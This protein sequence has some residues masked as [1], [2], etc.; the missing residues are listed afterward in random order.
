METLFK[1]I[2]YGIRSLAKH[3]GFAAIA[4]ITLALGIGANTA[5]FS[6]VNAVLLRPLPY[7]QPERLLRVWETNLARGGELEMTS[8]SNLLD[9]RRQNRSFQDLAAWQRLSSLTLTSQTPALQL[10]SSFVSANYFSLLGVPAALGRTFAVEESTAGHTRVVVISDELWRRQFGSNPQMIG[11]KILIEKENFEIIGVMPRGFKSPAG[12]AELWVPMNFQPNDIDRGQTYLQ[13]IGRLKPDFTLAQA[14]ADMDGVATQLAAQFPNSNRG[15]GI[16]LVSLAEQTVGSVRRALLIVLGGV[17]LVLLIACANV[18][19]LFLVRAAQ[20]QHE[21]AIRAALGASSRR[22][23]RQLLS[24]ASIVALCGGMLGLFAAVWALELLKAF[25]AGQLPRLDEIGIDRPTLIFT[26]AASLITGLLSGLAPALYVCRPNLNDALKD[27][28]S[29]TQTGGWRRNRLQS[30][31]VVAQVAVA[32]VLLS[33]AGLL[34]RSFVQLVKVNPGFTADG[35]LVARIALGD[36]YRQNNKQVNYFRELT[37]RLRRLP[38]VNEAGAATVLPMN[39]FGIDFD[40][41]YHR[42]EQ[43]EPP[44]A[45]APKAKFRAVTPEYFQA[46]EM[47]LHKGRGFVE[48]DRHDSPRVL[49][50]NQMLAERVWRAENPVGKQLRFF[51]AD[52]QT[53]EVVGVVGNT[54]SYGLVE[55]YQPELFVP[56]AQIPYTVMNVVIRT[57]GDPSASAVE[58]RRV[59]LEL[60]PYRPPHSIVA[61]RDLIS[62]SIARERFAMTWLGVLAAI[63]LV[64]ASVGIYSVI[65][66]VTAQ[67]TREVG[68]R[69]ALGAQTSDVLRLVVLKGMK[70]TLI[71]VVIGFA[72]ALGLT[73]LIGS[74]LFGV[75]SSDLMT[76]ISAS[77]LLIV[78]ALLACYVPARRA[79]KVDP[80]VALRYE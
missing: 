79:T 53:Y 47:P 75:T 22:L 55:D 50:V 59:I 6:V 14:Q 56:D 21:I 52:W 51:W 32:L 5:I 38:G 11:T 3:P 70:L 35:L 60:D 19:N 74:L 41:P 58:V 40:V 7:H 64:L 4:V 61:M 18:A 57:T 77:A 73:R 76:F 62:D 42:A 68:I 30:A 78:V 37:N 8:L 1:D 43:A 72:S 65:S 31:F 29:R 9:W 24:E 39:P 2:R 16:R 36:E 10:R 49:I 23:V 67:R 34:I 17:G 28:G 66:H 48:Q 25:A 45:A 33:G 15:R 13:V 12:E 20:R 80:L 71:G 69:L 46:M 63:A 54:K 27:S 26:I 44:R